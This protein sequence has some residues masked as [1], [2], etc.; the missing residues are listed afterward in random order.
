MWM[1]SLED[2]WLD[3]APLL[4]VLKPD[5][6][7]GEKDSKAWSRTGSGLKLDAMPLYGMQALNS[8]TRFRNSRIAS[9]RQFLCVKADR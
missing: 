7:E 8:A 3:K 6:S 1:V 5:D 9:C 4:G 2:R